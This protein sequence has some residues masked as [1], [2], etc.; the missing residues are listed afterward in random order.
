MRILHLVAIAVT[1][2]DSLSSAI[3]QRASPNLKLDLLEYIESHAPV[4]DTPEQALE[5]L[6]TDAIFHQKFP[7]VGKAL[8]VRALG[9]GL[10][11]SL[12]VTHVAT[13]CVSDIGHTVTVTHR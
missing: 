9:P 13:S 5:F 11:P 1:C 7:E 2:G 4:D 8:A 12:W 3:A 10:D 6:K